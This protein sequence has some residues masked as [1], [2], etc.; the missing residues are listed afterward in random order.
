VRVRAGQRLGGRSGR[1]VLLVWGLCRCW[2]LGFGAGP[3]QGGVDIACGPA[4]C[5]CCAVAEEVVEE[6]EVAAVASRCG[7]EGEAEA[8]EGVLDTAVVDGH[9]CRCCC[10]QDG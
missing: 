1:L 4:V 7:G 9:P 3:V 6:L 2:R 8:V 10:G 5:A